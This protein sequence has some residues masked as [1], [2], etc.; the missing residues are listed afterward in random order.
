MGI[1]K[2]N[3]FLYLLITSEN[4]TPSA[5]HA[6]GAFLKKRA[7]GYPQSSS[8]FRSDL[9]WNHPACYWGSPM[10]L[11][12]SKWK[13]PSRPPLPCVT[14]QPKEAQGA[15][16][17]GKEWMVAKCLPQNPWEFQDP[18]VGLS[19][20]YSGIIARYPKMK[21][22]MNPMDPAVPSERKYDWGMM[23]RGLAVPSQTV[24]MDP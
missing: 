22:F 18:N 1:P 12:T 21:R 17:F 13:L 5:S 20:D 9:P 8:M 19:W 23:T 11:E 3:G 14:P 15:S 2:T 7:S 4:E 16:S 6:H 10:T 24:A